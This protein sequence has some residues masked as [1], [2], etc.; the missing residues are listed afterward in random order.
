MKKIYKTPRTELFKIQITNHLLIGS[1]NKEIGIDDSGGT[2]I[3]LGED[4]D[5]ALGRQ[6]ENR[7]SVWDNIW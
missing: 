6:Q 2:P 4:P 7:S 5:A 3:D 1:D